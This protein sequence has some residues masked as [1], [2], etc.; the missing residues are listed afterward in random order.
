MALRWKRM[1]P[2][3]FIFELAPS[4][5]LFEGIRL[6][7]QLSISYRFAAYRNTAWLQAL[8]S[9]FSEDTHASILESCLWSATT[10]A[11][12]YHSHSHRHNTFAEIKWLQCVTHFAEAG[13]CFHN[14]GVWVSACVYERIA[15]I[16]QQD[17]AARQAFKCWKGS[18][19]L[20]SGKTATVT[21]PVIMPLAILPARRQ[22]SRYWKCSK[23][24]K[25]SGSIIQTQENKNKIS[26][27]ARGA[28]KYI[29]CSFR[30]RTSLETLEHAPQAVNNYCFT[31]LVERGKDNILW[32][33]N[34]LPYSCHLPLMHETNWMG[35]LPW[36]HPNEGVCREVK[37][38]RRKR[39]RGGGASA[40]KIRERLLDPRSASRQQSCECE[41]KRKLCGILI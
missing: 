2:L 14:D 38:S 29:S 8:K 30:V 7:I 5:F 28:V 17:D 32:G 40:T 24:G 15:S 39:R 4:S 26:K 34:A 21:R 13:F 27:S 12:V 16:L 9:C 10:L 3:E 20:V 19:G 37:W 6:T 31:V 23:S 25:K 33:D 18:A 35:A 11:H 1:T 41:N 36:S 22:G